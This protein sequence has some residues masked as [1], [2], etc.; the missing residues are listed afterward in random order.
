MSIFT[1]S[2]ER[3]EGGGFLHVFVIT[4]LTHFLTEI[5]AK[6]YSSSSEK[7]NLAHL[8]LRRRGGSP[9]N[10]NAQ[11]VAFSAIKLIRQIHNWHGN[12]LNARTT[13]QKRELNAIEPSIPQERQPKDTAC[14]HNFSFLIKQ[15]PSRSS[16][17]TVTV[18][19]CATSQ[20]ASPNSSGAP[21]SPAA[22]PQRII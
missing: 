14:R 9:W 8:K 11:W 18:F 6:V 19:G 3:K 15:S 13:M 10:C 4:F 5:Y 21:T 22:S 12:T 20:S 16:E 7:G 2:Y 1:Y 17:N